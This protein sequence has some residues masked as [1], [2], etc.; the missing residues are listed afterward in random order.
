MKKLL[1]YILPVSLLFGT[2]TSCQSDELEAGQGKVAFAVSVSDDVK[3]QSR[4]TETLEQ[5]CTI[6]VYDSNERL[7]RKYH[8]I[9]EVPSELWMVSGDY[10]A[11]AWAGKN[12]P[13]S[14]TEKYFKGTAPFTIEK[15]STQTV[16]IKC[17]IANV[18]ASV[19]MTQEA[20]SML[21]DYTV[22]IANAGGSL[23]FNA[24]NTD[25]KGYYMMGSNESSLSWTLS[26]TMPNGVIYSTEGTIN[27][28]KAAH[29]Y[30]L[31]FKYNDKPTEVGGSLFTVEVDE[32][33]VEK[34]DEVLIM[35]APRITCGAYDLSQPTVRE[36]GTF[37]KAIFYVSSATTLKSLKVSSPALTTLGFPS[38]FIDKYAASQAILEN[39]KTLGLDISDVQTSS[40]ENGTLVKVSFSQELLNKLENGNYVFTISATDNRNDETA[41]KTSTIEWNVE[42][43]SAL[44][45]VSD[46][47]NA[48]VKQYSAT[49]RGSIVKDEATDIVFKYR[50]KGDTA[51]TEAEA[52]ISG[53][54]FSAK[55]TG[56]A[57]F[58]AYEYKAACSGYETQPKEFTTGS[59]TPLTNG[60]FEDW[61]QSGKT[62][63]PSASGTLYW[64]SGNWGA[65]TV[66]DNITTQD[67]EFKHGGNS[68]IK[69]SSKY[70][71]I[72]FAAGNVFI[73]KYLKT[74]GS[75]GILGFGRPFT[76]RPKALKGYAR[77]ISKTIDRTTSDGVAAGAVKGANDW[78]NVYVALVDGTTSTAEG[79]TWPVVIKT[80]KSYRQL[81][82]RNGSNVIGFGEII[83][84]E[85]T[86]GEGFVEF[87][88]PI[89]YRSD[90]TPANLV[91]VAS[92][93]Y[94]GDYFS[95]GDGSTL[96]L[97]DLEFVYE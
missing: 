5:N 73:G 63:I 94:W 19:N 86:A 79:E 56:L 49:V 18:V 52:T 90:A 4:S 72:K 8:G 6:Y 7:V 23:D 53:S 65:T 67:T 29:E 11:E 27:D 41:D 97:D 50:K 83:W 77:Y 57:P 55:L 30:R 12:E 9:N 31:T 82:D 33:V 36:K 32:S 28:V 26:G 45:K 95:G 24:D 1:N 75:D 10:R 71:V 88:I 22:T 80:K 48:D 87:E 61:Y 13:A 51:W 92:A 37:S 89:D 20:A 58:T 84:K 96:W 47:E 14:F 54:E 2:L 78:G 74:D 35:A 70:I 91:L 21:A 3:V 76:S 59:A 46:T 17:T 60:G 66:G 39:F 15:G 81:F 34:N 38:D 93:S 62:L 16:E 25:A 68:S 40:E 64:D 42:V 69:M 44:I 85:S 43:S